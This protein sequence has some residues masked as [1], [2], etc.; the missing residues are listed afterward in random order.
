[1]SPIIINDPLYGFI[2]VPP[3]LLSALLD[4]PEVQR[5]DHIRQ[6]G[7]SSFVYPSAR[8][9]RKQHSLG[10]LHL[11]QEALTVLSQKGEFFF[12]PESE[13]AMA[14]ILL[15]DVGH[16]PFSHVLEHDLVP[17]V[18]HEEITL[19]V[20]ERINQRLKGELAYAIQ[21]FKDDYPK[22]CLHELLSSQLDVD[23]LDYVNRDSFYCGVQEGNIGAARITKMLSIVDDRLVVEHKGLYTVEHYLMTRRLM[24]WQVYLHKTVVA[25]EE[26]L[27]AVLR[28]AK[29]LAA[30]GDTLFASPALAYF[31][32]GVH[33]RE[34]FWDSDEALD[35]Y[36]LLT[37]AD[38]L[39][40]IGVW[41]EHKDTIL[42]Q[43]A[44]A[45]YERRLFKVEVFDGDVPPALVE[46][47]M[48]ALRANVQQQ[49]GVS[50]EEAH[51]FVSCRKV[52]KEMYSADGA[53]IG[54]LQRDGSVSDVGQ[55]SR[56]VH[57]DAPDALRDS[58]IYVF[59][60]RES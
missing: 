18:S 40:A 22:R 43:L 31:L 57:T 7:T 8:H 9:S 60:L 58:K 24:Y 42:S 19:S 14:A 17:G 26:V 27:R 29:H 54:I 52:S 25:A 16:G 53:G 3:G 34:S 48:A 23:R 28:R 15:H 33:T 39:C 47:R 41:R 56:I 36:L 35:H 6:L 51:Y 30:A 50:A 2:S 44:K 38:L 12:E 59:H 55:L 4:T 49:L 1:M 20:M 32:Y 46:E 21:I 45:F 11:M 5:L 13:G 37:D 10:A